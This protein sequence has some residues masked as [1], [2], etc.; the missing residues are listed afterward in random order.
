[1]KLALGLVVAFFSS[2]TFAAGGS[3]YPLE[4]IELDYTDKESLQRGLATY[5]HYCMGCHSLKYQRYERTATDLGVDHEIMVQAVV[6]SDKKIGDLGSIAMPSKGAAEWFGAPPPDLTLVARKRSPEWVY[7]YMKTFYVD[8]S[9][10]LGVNNKVFPK[11]GMPHVL[12]PLQGLQHA[13]CDEAITRD[14]VIAQADLGSGQSLSERQCGSL[15][16]VE[17]TAQ[18]SA[19]EYDRLIY[20]LV[21]FLEYVGEPTK[22]KAHDIGIYVLLFLMLFFVFA[23]LLKR[24]YWKDVR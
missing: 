10:P 5:S 19:A 16:V 4:Q 6:P 14:N 1:M 23:Y 21:N 3:T 22:A 2:V 15:E 12:E 17:G 11:V 8:P 18:L 7:T 20:D 13:V 9:R 24:E